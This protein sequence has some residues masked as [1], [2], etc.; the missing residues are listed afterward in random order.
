MDDLCVRIDLIAHKD[1]ALLE[2][3]IAIASMI[4]LGSLAS[5]HA[6]RLPYDHMSSPSWTQIL[7]GLDCQLP[8]GHSFFT[9]RS[10]VPLRAIPLMTARRVICR[11]LAN[12]HLVSDQK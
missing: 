7:L 1:L 10:K 6:W 2:R 12:G 8:Q 9:F 4:R 5:D 3:P 11:S